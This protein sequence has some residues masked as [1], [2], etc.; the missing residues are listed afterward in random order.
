MAVMGKVW[1]R[2]AKVAKGTSWHVL[3]G[4]CAEGLPFSVF[5]TTLIYGAQDQSYP[6]QLAT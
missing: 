6:N 2:R 1:I 3:P 4:F 5:G